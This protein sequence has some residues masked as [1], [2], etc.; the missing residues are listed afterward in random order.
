MR[1]L[2]IILDK[3]PD[4]EIVASF[5]NSHEAKDYLHNN[6]VE[7]AFFDVEM[8]EINGIELAYDCLTLPKIPAVIFITGHEQY[9]MKAWG[10]EAVDY[11]LK[12]Y[13]SDHVFRAVQKARKL[14]PTFSAHEGTKSIEIK[15]FPRF[16]IFVNNTPVLIKCKKGKEM[17]AYLVDAQGRW[18]GSEEIISAL[19]P[20]AP[21]DE[22]SKNVF[23]VTGFRL[24]KELEKK[25]L[26][27]IMEYENGNY[28]VVTDNFSC[29]YYRY[30]NNEEVP[31]SGE[32]LSEYEWAEMTAAKLYFKKQH[33]KN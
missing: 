31:F 24:K 15:C 1:V 11:I 32:Y 22:S 4:V 7:L 16:E 29:D 2:Q 17:L 13:S 23:Y 25:D 10:V 14:L 12:P 3:I 28:R 8:P 9:A 19:W 27:S 21:F 33:G 20:D 26:D 5:T 6:E 18:V 30:L